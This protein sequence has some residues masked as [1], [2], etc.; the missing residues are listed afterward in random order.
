MRRARR[1]RIEREEKQGRR[2][3]V[4]SKAAIATGAGVGA[5]VLF[6]PAAD[7]ATFT[8]TNLN[9]A[10]AGSLRQAVI[11]ANRLDG[12]DTVVFQSGLSG[13]ITL[14]GADSDIEIYF[15]GI[16]IRGP[17]ANQIT[18]DGNNLDRIFFATDFDNPNEPVRISD[19]T[20]TRG[21][22]GNGGFGGAFY[23]DNTGAVAPNFAPDVTIADS[24]LTNN[25]AGGGGAIRVDH[26]SLAILNTALTGNVATTYG[27]G[28]LYMNDAD[29]G[30]TAL[31]IRESTFSGN[32]TNTDSEGGGAFKF[33]AQTETD[34][35][36]LIENSNF[37]NNSSANDGGAMVFYGDQGGQYIG[38]VTIRGTTVAGNTA[39]ERGGGILAR[40]IE[41]AL[42]IENSTISGNTADSDGDGSG[43][44][45]GIGSYNLPDRPRTILNSTVVA[46]RAGDRGGGIYAFRADD[47]AQ[48]GDDVFGVS[49]TI[50]AANTA[51]LGPDLGEN[52]TP[53]DSFNVGFSLIQNPAGA[54]ITESPPGSNLTGV[55]AQLG[56]LANNGGPTQTHEPL[57][58][59]PVIDAGIG[60]GLTTDQRGFPRAVGIPSIPNRSGSDGTDIG[61]V[62][63][64]A[65]RDLPAHAF[66]AGAAGETLSGT[67]ESDLMTGGAG[68]DTLNGLAGTDCVSGADGDD[69]ANGDEGADLVTGDAGNDTAT[70]GAGKDN[71]DGGDGKDR[72]KGNGGKDKVKGAGG[73]D[74]INGD[75]GKDKIAGGAGKDRIKGGNAKDKIKGNGGKDKIN[76][77]DRKV[78]KVNCGGGKDTAKVD[79][80]DR[81]SRNCEVV[82]EKRR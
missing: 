23:S 36:A 13:T 58:T 40:S 21:L 18:V 75:G 47:P 68:N 50:V 61:S 10:G 43:Y 57:F 80:I 41:G 24:V 9:N 33:Y 64:Q 39:M 28:A 73:K 44:G 52:A 55:D 32:A 54:T 7:A 65:C 26:G 69:T 48:P 60:N 46:N 16:D 1:R 25:R 35:G 17:G 34:G 45:G 2:I 5:T 53:D 82:K 38:D 56:P 19:L 63:V 31:T 15:D 72:L 22:Y 71:V 14:T 42:R 70:G 3:G 77:I 81:V 8:V 62:E 20:L 29:P 27:G 51:P 4:G 67:P 37:V 76:S 59:S 6:A 74:S 30:K 12:D 78:D 49:S 66:P 11:D 79:S